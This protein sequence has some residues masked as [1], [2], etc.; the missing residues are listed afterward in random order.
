MGCGSSSVETLETWTE[1]VEKLEANFFR[2]LGWKDDEYVAKY[3]MIEM[4]GAPYRV[5][6][7]YFGDQAESKKTLILTHGFMANVA[8]FL[9]L[10]KP[11]AAEYRLI[12]FDNCNWG[13]NTRSPDV[14]A[15]HDP[16]LAERWILDFYE[17][18]IEALDN[19]PKTF[20]LSGHSHGGF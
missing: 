11:L 18:T 1:K 17:R 2:E 15:C 20:L 4:D 8:A 10:L 13:L 19:S 14:P 12:A 3:T 6:T 16:D 9:G 7:Y 5:R